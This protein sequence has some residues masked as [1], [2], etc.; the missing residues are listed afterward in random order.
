MFEILSN[1]LDGGK[2]PQAVA[3][4]LYE[5]QVIDRG[6]LLT[7]FPSS[8]VHLSG[9][10]GDIDAIIS[11]DMQES[12]VKEWVENVLESKREN[13]HK[14]DALEWV[15][16]RIQE[17]LAQRTDLM[18]VSGVTLPDVDYIMYVIIFGI[19]NL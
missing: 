5:L 17:S 1:F 15:K 18:P 4:R 12:D 7:D 6:R 8:Q 3:E 13:E 2:H 19:V 16:K 11:P 14:W 9:T 10:A